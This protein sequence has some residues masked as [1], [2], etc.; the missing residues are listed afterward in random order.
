MQ[1]MKRRSRWSVNDVYAALA[2]FGDA[3]WYDRGRMAVLV[4]HPQVE[5]VAA[6][7]IDVGDRRRIDMHAGPSRQPPGVEASRERDARVADRVRPPCHERGC[8]DLR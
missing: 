1:A 4:V 3:R 2:G 5:V 7:A 8:R 6:D